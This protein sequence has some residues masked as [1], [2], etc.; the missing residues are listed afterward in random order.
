MDDQ[1]PVQP[2]SPTQGEPTP[3]VGTPPVPP[4]SPFSGITIDLP[5]VTPAS[6]EPQP[7][8]PAPA[9]TYVVPATGTEVPPPQPG[10]SQPD[11]PFIPQGVAPIS[12]PP[13]P[14]GGSSMVRR[15]IMVLVFLF[16]AGIVFAGARFALGF[17]GGVKEVTISYWGLWE[18]ESI[19][20]PVISA[21]QVA[22]PKIKVEYVKQSPKQYR[23]RL[24]AAITRGDGPDAFR[25]HNSWV[26]MLKNELALVP[27]TT[28]TP[29]EFSSTFYPIAGASL[30]AGSSIFGIPLEVDGLGLYYNEYLFAAAGVKVPTTW[31]EVLNVVPKLT[32]RTGDTI[33]TSAIALGTWGNVE[34]A[35]DILATMM[36]QN[37]ANLVNPTGKEAEETLVFYRKFAT[38]ADPVYTW[39]DTLDN[40]M[41]AFATGRVAMIL[42]PSWRAFDIKQINPNL[43]FKIAPIPQL[44]GS[45]VTWA[46]FWVEGVSA[47]SKYPEQSWEFIKYLTS[48]E[49]ATKLYTEESKIRLFGE[50]YARVELASTIADDPYAGAFI[51]QATSAKT[52]PLASRTFDNGLNDKLIKYMEDGVN[53]LAAG[54]APAAVLRTMSSGFQQVLSQYGLV[55]AAPPATQ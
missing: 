7:S 30:V 41:Y 28:M 20:A 24:Q 32:V 38:P 8:E 1:N 34:A 42:A 15:L 3:S 45:T 48:K 9:D 40:S 21:F 54:S 36:L 27:K 2:V 22:H 11:N 25:F 5:Q 44:P 17:L 43:R 55:S 16:L 50:P 12:A 46:S 18:N 19:I 35:S 52:F 13:A 51:K 49:G 31:E 14:H 23:E 37:G 4:S 6:P 33:T 29:A 26:P 39:N 10:S 47:K 53:G